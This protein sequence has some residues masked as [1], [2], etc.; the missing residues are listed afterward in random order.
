MTAAVRSCAVAVAGLPPFRS[1]A[2]RWLLCAAAALALAGCG[3]PE[4]QARAE[5][6]AER[7]VHANQ[8]FQRDQQIWRE[9]RHRELLKPDGWTSLVGLHPIEP[10]A[11]YFGSDADNG[12]RLGVGPGHIGLLN[13]DKGRLRFVPE[14]GL[15]LTLNEQPL[16]GAAVLL[17]DDSPAGPTRI[18]FDEGRGVLT[19]IKRGGRWYLRVRHADAPSRTGFSAIEYWPARQD[20][21][22]S[23]KFVAHPAGQTIEVANIIGVVEPTPN[24]GAV[25][26]ERD[27]R[28]YRIE[29]LDQGGEELMLV[30]ADRTSG[31]GSYS[32][33]RFL[34]VPR[35]NPQG[36]VTVDF[37]K[38]YNPPCAFTPFATCPLPPQ[39]NRLDLEVTAGEKTYKAAAG[40]A[41][42]S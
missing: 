25:E 34:D 18:G 11:H 9:Q 20:W 13:L 7:A 41:H 8:D 29:A 28:S 42:A 19:A 26:F 23:A 21:K 1:G 35:P 12:I 2:P 4:Q 39:G 40:A 38:A 22:L 30:F 31:H 24:P 36:K 10:G 17:A 15:A 16:K 27:G 3:S 14:R 33:G 6:E 32:A 5:R 37:N